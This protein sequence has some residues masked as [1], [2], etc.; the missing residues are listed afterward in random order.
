MQRSE[1]KETENES[2]QETDSSAVGLLDAAWGKPDFSSLEEIANRYKNADLNSS[3]LPNL[4]LK[5]GLDELTKNEIPEDLKNGN[6]NKLP[7]DEKPTAPILI[8]LPYEPPQVC[9]ESDAWKR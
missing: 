2:T 9:S 7:V 1:F 8:V 5:F 4:E 6:I 3:K